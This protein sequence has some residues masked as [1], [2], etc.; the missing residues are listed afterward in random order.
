M[1]S[2]NLAAIA[3]EAGQVQ[4]IDVARHYYSMVWQLSQY[5][6]VYTGATDSCLSGVQHQ[7]MPSMDCV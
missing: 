2:L 7:L 5:N 6:K 4:Q 1:L 3:D